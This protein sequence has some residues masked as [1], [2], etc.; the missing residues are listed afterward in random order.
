MLKKNMI[1]DDILDNVSG[2]NKYSTTDMKACAKCKI[3]KPA[4]ILIN[5]ICPECQSSN[6]TPGVQIGKADKSNAITA[7]INSKT[8]SGGNSDIMMC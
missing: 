2:G 1:D 7:N 5:G 6:T 3:L 4:H 8:F